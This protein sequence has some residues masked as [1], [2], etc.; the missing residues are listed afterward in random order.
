MPEFLVVA[1][2]ET[3]ARMV[4]LLAERIFLE[5][6]EDWVREQCAEEVPQWMQEDYL[7]QWHAPQP[8]ATGVTWRAVRQFAREGSFRQ[9][10]GHNVAGKARGIYYA[11]A[12]NALFF[13]SRLRQSR[14][15]DALV[16]VV[17]L[18]DQ[19]ERREGLEQA[20]EEAQK[21]DSRI[22]I[23]LAT[24]DPKQEAWVLNGFICEGDEE[25]TLEALRQELGFDPCHKAEE[26]QA[27]DE[28]AKRSAHRV[29]RALLGE[30]RERKEKC[31]SATPLATLRDRGGKT[32]LAAFLAEVTDFLLPL[33]TRRQA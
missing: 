3:D 20:R 19:P 16:W 11:Q 28:T 7:P 10:F 32:N 33:L 29:V 21:A 2:G 6:G 23:V 17:D 5:E 24:P 18:D 27:K 22:V 15:I 4:R 12:R 9:A 25:P 31:W 1:E 14:R 26:L 8:N 13:L 30:S